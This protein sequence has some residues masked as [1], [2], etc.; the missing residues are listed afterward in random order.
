MID[1]QNENNEGNECEEGD[2]EM[3]KNME[4]K[5]ILLYKK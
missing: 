4:V 1:E 5:K 3:I 2:N